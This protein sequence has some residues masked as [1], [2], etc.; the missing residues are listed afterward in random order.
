M[1]RKDD[2]KL[3]LIVVAFT[4]LC[5][6]LGVLAA[7]PDPIGTIALHFLTSQGRNFPLSAD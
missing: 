3:F 2:I 1:A 6:S 7:T 4:A 5:S